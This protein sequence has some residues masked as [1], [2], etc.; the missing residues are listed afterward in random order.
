MPLT[1]T[2]SSKNSP[3]SVLILMTSWSSCGGIIGSFTYTHN[4][5]IMYIYRQFIYDSQGCMSIHISVCVSKCMFIP[6]ICLA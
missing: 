1:G 2:I 4:I 3:R 5:H 6:G